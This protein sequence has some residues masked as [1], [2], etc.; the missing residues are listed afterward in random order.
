MGGAGKFELQ[1]PKPNPIAKSKSAGLISAAPFALLIYSRWLVR[2]SDPRLDWRAL[3]SKI[4]LR[5]PNSVLD[6]RAL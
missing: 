3:N 5:N 4:Q 2:N 1:N 6:W